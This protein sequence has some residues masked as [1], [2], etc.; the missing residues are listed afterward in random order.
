MTTSSA[1]HVCAALLLACGVVCSAAQ[2]KPIYLEE[3][4]D[5]LVFNEANDGLEMRVLPLDL[6][7]R[8]VPNPLPRGAL[9]VRTIENPGQ[10]LEVSWSSIA[11]VELFERKL[12]EDAQQLMR[13][14]DLNEAYGCLARLQRDYPRTFG[15]QRMWVSFLKADALQ[16]YS[17]KKYLHALAILETLYERAPD[18][19]GVEQAISA[20]GQEV[21][22]S[23]WDNEDYQAMSASI[24]SLST[25]FPGLEIASVAAWQ[26]RLDGRF[27]SLMAEAQSALDGGDSL[28]ARRAAMAAK[29]LRPSDPSADRLLIEINQRDPTLRV[30]IIGASTPAAYVALDTPHARRIASLTDRQLVALDGVGASGGIYSTPLGEVESFDSGRAVRFTLDDSAFDGEMSA[31]ALARE[32]ARLADSGDA[33]Y[34]LLAGRL[35]QVE[36][37]GPN[38]VVASFSRSHP[39]PESLLL[40]PMPSQ[41]LPE[42]QAAWTLKGED[43]QRRVFRRNAP[44]SANPSFT[45]VEEIPYARDSRAVND[46]IRGELHLLANPPPWQVARLEAARS[47]RVGQYETATLHCLLIGKDSRLRVSREARRAFCYGI[48]R[49]VIVRDSILAGAN[50]AGAMPITGPFPAGSSL[51]DPLRYAYNDALVVRTHQP[52]LAAMLSAVAQIEAAEDAEAP[53]PLLMIHPGSPVARVACPSIQSMMGALGV[54]IELL[55]L[56]EDELTSSPPPHDLRYAEIH[57]DEPMVDAW[58]LLGPGG[59]SGDCTTT[60]LIELQKLQ[61]VSSSRRISEALAQIHEIAY[62]DL[63]IIPL[64]Q[65]VDHYAFHTSLTGAPDSLVTL[66]QEIDRM[67]WDS[68]EGG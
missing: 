57:V 41:V 34:G 4:F 13:K 1:S 23:A 12:L 45:L 28:A 37:T 15:L 59:L 20:V 42:P 65:M 29:A 55:E 19:P 56:S 16:K 43:Q 3:A 64:W 21:L 18:A 49:D 62:S 61:G 26:E 67:G 40:G 48:A 51:G 60:M 22:Q 9:I 30:G 63:P 10:A 25:Q 7:G 52:R 58:P 54:E 44:M 32:I 50:I 8:R 11:T 17:Q 5:T 14:R 2:G 6:P 24:T 68:G 31:A 27:D 36:V 38:E 47:V 53:E 35:T 66:Y 46:L 33:R 39:R